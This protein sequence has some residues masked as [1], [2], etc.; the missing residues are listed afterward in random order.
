MKGAGEALRPPSTEDLDPS[1]DRERILDRER[2][3]AV[4]A[5][6][7]AFCASLLFL[8][9]I[10]VQQ[11]ADLYTGSSTALQLESLHD[12]ASTIFAGA[13]VRALAF[14]ALI[15][16]LLYLFRAAQARN[17][18]VQPSLVA[19]VFIGPVLFAA[20]GIVVALGI[21]QA[22]SDFSGLPPESQ[23]SY[24]E[25]QAQVK[26]RPNDIDK[27][28]IYSA[29]DSLE[30]QQ[31]DGGFYAV[32][33]FPSDDE[34]KIVSDLD[35]AS[36]DHETDSDTGT[37]PPDA[38]AT[39]VTDNSTTLQAGYGLEL[40]GR[41]GLIIGMVYVSLQALRTGLL[42]RFIGSL[43][44]ALGAAVILIP[45]VVFFSAVIWAFFL[46]YL[47]FLFIGRLPGGRPPAWE[48]AKAI[49]WQRP[50]DEPPERDGDAI[51]GEA[52]E[53][54]SNG[55]GG[56]EPSRSAATRQRRKRKRRN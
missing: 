52:T 21:T 43:G 53:V 44:I 29:G 54:E 50:G 26:E 7:L 13:V 55:Q 2:R 30:V 6:I 35:D 45:P 23:R 49:P 20:A 10:V 38:Q 3:W 51:E 28:T 9:P 47:G 5:A 17:P 19:F 31:A 33:K 22:A 37:G 24:Q 42:T 4:P 48:T 56:G 32:S 27:V 1:V 11:T 18:R 36:I 12:H 16:P 46:G 41:L 14:A 8:A 39:D 40:A 34:S 25:F 15:G